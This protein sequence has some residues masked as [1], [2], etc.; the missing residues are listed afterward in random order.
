MKIEGSK[1]DNSNS[2]IWNTRTKK[3]KCFS[4]CEIFLLPNSTVTRKVKI[5][6]ILKNNFLLGK[7]IPNATF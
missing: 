1:P 6:H 7:R 4:V 5:F 3:K 2:S